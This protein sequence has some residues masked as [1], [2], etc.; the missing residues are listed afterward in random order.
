M[1]SLKS[2]KLKSSSSR[3]I[4][5]SKGRVGHFESS[6]HDPLTLFIKHLIFFSDNQY[7]GPIPQF[8]KKILT[9]IIY[10]RFINFLVIIQNSPYA[11]LNFQLGFEKVQHSF[12]AYLKYHFSQIIKFFTKKGVCGV[13]GEPRALTALTAMVLS[14]PMK[15]ICRPHFE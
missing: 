8:V 11:Y 14:Y 4:F 7:W 9:V 13:G 12:Q 10:H 15:S 2:F 5:K 1:N 3:L 6:G